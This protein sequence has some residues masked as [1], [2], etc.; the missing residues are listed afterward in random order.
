V[1]FN[2]TRLYQKDT[3]YQPCSTRT[4]PSSCISERTPRQGWDIKRREGKGRGRSG[5]ERDQDSIPAVLFSHFRGQTGLSD[6][7]AHGLL[8]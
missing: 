7:V 1:I 6:K 3:V 8:T 5:R 4:D 2:C